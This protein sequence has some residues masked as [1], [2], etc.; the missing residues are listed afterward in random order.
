MQHDAQEIISLILDGIHEDLNR[1]KSKPYVLT[2]QYKESESNIAISESWEF[3]LKRNQSIIVDLMHG[4][5]KTS[6]SC[7]LC[8]QSQATCDPFCL[9]PLSIPSKESYCF[10][11]FYIPYGTSRNPIK[12]EVDLKK[13]ETALEMRKAIAQSIGM[14]EESFIICATG[15]T[16]L[17]PI[18]DIISVEKIKSAI[19]TSKTQCHIMSFQKKNNK[20]SELKIPLLI[21]CEIEDTQKIEYIS[22]ARPV[23]LEGIM[24]TADIYLEIFKY[25]WKYIKLIHEGPTQLKDDESSIKNFVLDILNTTTL[26]ENSTPEMLLSPYFSLNFLGTQPTCAICK[27]KNC[28]GCIFPY[29]TTLKLKDIATS[30]PYFQIELVWSRRGRRVTTS[31]LN[32]YDDLNTGQM[33]ITN[34]VTLNDCF[35]SFIATEILDEQNAWFCSTCQQHVAATKATLIAKAPLILI[36]ALKRFKTFGSGMK[37]N[38]LVEFPICGL[39]LSKYKW[40]NLTEPTKYNLFAVCNHYGSLGGGHYNAYALNAITKKWYLFD[41]SAVSN[42]NENEI[43]SSSAYVLFYRREDVDPLKIDPKIIKQHLPT[44]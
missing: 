44:E 24:T 36:V 39:D 27:Q 4:L 12:I 40:G 7:P 32:Q 31:V 6:L 17:N 21:G 10:S 30:D 9:I 19:T 3:Y 16:V 15:S 38:E 1:V 43:V 28:H 5:L 25:F 41:D 23:F 26:V 20:D 2:K 11:I 29:S 18:S 14:P 22:F 34:H 33:K 8:H 13:Q 35:E 37:N 42:I